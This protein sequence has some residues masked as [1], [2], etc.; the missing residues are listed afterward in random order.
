[1]KKGKENSYHRWYCKDCKRYSIGRRRLKRKML[2][3]HFP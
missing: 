3:L 1:M 2:I